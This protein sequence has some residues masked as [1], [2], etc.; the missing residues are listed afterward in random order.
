MRSERTRECIRKRNI[1]VILSW[2]LCFG[3]LAFMLIYGFATKWTG[4]D[5][6]VVNHFKAILSIW[7]MALLPLISISF[8]V[9]D[10]IKPTVRMINVILAAYLVSEGFM[11]FIGAL[12]LL[13]T[14]LLSHLISKYQMAI[15]TNKEIDQR[16][17]NFIR[18]ED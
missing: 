11:Y 17:P 3:M 14:Y 8:L 7:L 12:M 5:N 6:E 9:K 2:V 15:I 16:E 1:Y 4:G 13:D 18:K 10:K